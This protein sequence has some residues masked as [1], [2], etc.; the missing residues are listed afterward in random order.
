MQKF[1]S[2]FLV[3]TGGALLL[4]LS[5]CVNPTFSA[6]PSCS[7]DCSKKV[8]Y[9]DTKEAREKVRKHEYVTVKNLLYA[10]HG[11]G[12]PP[13]CRSVWG[14]NIHTTPYETR[15][16]KLQ[17]KAMKLAILQFK[18]DAYLYTFNFVT[19]HEQNVWFLDRYTECVHLGGQVIRFTEKPTPPGTALPGAM[20]Q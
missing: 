5:G 10:D 11:N 7:P 3:L 15:H 8:V 17:K 6:D 20:S 19:T 18:G 14:G 1:F 12:L 13:L 4:S 16:P 9:P 2:I